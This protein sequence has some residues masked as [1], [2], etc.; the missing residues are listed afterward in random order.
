MRLKYW[1]ENI[2][3]LILNRAKLHGMTYIISE[4]IVLL[5]TGYG[6]GTKWSNED[7]IDLV[8]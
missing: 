6:N 2:E 3:L 4:I 1:N 8:Q 7:F 5:D